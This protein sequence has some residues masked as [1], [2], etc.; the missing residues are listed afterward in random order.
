MTSVVDTSV[1]YFTS[2]MLGGP[3]LNGLPG[4]KIAQYDACLDIGF[5]IKAAT[6]LT[7]TAGV[8]RLAFVGTHSAI[9]DSVI[10]L[11]G[12]LTA[13]LNGEQKIIGAGAGFITFATAVADG[14]HSGT[15]TFKMAPAGFTKVF[16][17]P[18][19]AVYRSRSPESRACFLRVDDSDGRHVRVVAYEA[20][21]DANTGVGP[22]PTEGQAPGGGYWAK[23]NA[24]I[25]APVAWVLASDGRSVIDSTAAGAH[26]GASTQNCFTRFW[27]D[28]VEFSG[29]FDPYLWVLSFSLQS[30]PN[31]MNEG[32][33]DFGGAQ[34]FAL[35]RRRTG[36]AGAVLGRRFPYTG[37]ALGGSGADSFFGVFPQP[38]AVGLYTTRLF[39]SESQ[40]YPARGEVP[41]WRHIPHTNLYNSLK[42]FQV[43][44]QASQSFVCVTCASAGGAWASDPSS[45]YGGC[46][47]I[48]ITGPWQGGV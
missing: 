44:K 30:D 6:S 37:S 2:Q 9:V 25:A 5:D 15:I 48:D 19:K 35:S 32:A 27:G 34:G 1:K 3:I 23:S 42:M 20:M 18:N 41:G 22:F 7:V 28:G 17:E 39:L 16:S 38:A 47:L 10:L 45:S 29:E 43:L 14:T 36:E 46:G 4:S 11:E 13:A 24:A 12:S 26:A 8:A 33:L 31:R 21:S 40:N